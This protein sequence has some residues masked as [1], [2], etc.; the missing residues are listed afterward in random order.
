MAA[1]IV[2]LDKYRAPPP[3]RV[4]Q[5]RVRQKSQYELYPLPF[6]N[7]KKL[8]T[9]DVEPT[10]NYSIDCETGRVFAIE[11]L[12]SCDKTYGWASLM[13]SIVIDMIEAGDT[14]NT[15]IVV[16]F[17]GIIGHALV[18]RARLIHREHDGRE[19]PT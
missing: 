18:S 19:S 14:K 2:Q 10:G 12:K 9:W 16:G 4:R 6:F 15:G 1:Q 7:R 3:K 8:S 13:A 11:F 17:M 5:K